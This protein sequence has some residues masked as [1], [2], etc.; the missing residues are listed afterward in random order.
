MDPSGTAWSYLADGFPRDITVLKSNTTVVYADGTRADVGNGIYDHHTYMSD[1]DKPIPGWFNCGS[2]NS[3]FVSLS[4]GS[5][6]VGGS[7]DKY[8]GYFTTPD[9]GFNSGYY[10]GQKDRL[11]LNGDVI[12]YT[13]ETRTVYT[14]NEI[15][16][17]PGKA[18]GMSEA[19]M[20]VMVPG[21]CDGQFGLVLPNAEKT[22][23][24]KGRALNVTRDVTIL[25]FSK[26]P[27]CS[28]NTPVS[29][30]LDS[31]FN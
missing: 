17:I 25:A 22:F 16:Y 1:M 14:L 3:A 13:D 8:G 4:P 29:L 9:G 12:N 11:V 26:P 31:L 28:R 30:I 19:S 10:I 18:K 20:Y 27:S 2:R 21:Q 7:E 5:L 23:T 24:V 6:F 15:E